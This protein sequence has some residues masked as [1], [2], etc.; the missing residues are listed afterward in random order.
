MFLEIV[1]LLNIG[2]FGDFSAALLALKHMLNWFP[3][4]LVE[5]CLVHIFQEFG[6]GRCLRFQGWV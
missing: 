2:I 5:V 1:Q 3:F 6:L 4:V